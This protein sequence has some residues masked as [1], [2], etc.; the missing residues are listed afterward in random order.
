MEYLHSEW[1]GNTLR[2]QG[3]L[4]WNVPFCQLPTYLH[5]IR[6]RES[7]CIEIQ[8]PWPPNGPERLL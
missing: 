2:L 3:K 1:Q 8:G 5:T 6:D 4:W 7:G